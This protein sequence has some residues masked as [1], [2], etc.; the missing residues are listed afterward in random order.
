MKASHAPLIIVGAGIAGLCAALAA[1]PHPVRLLNRTRAL[2]GAAADAATA[3]A[4][5]GIAAALAAGDDVNAHVDDTV[6][7]GAGHNDHAAVAYLCA[8]APAAIGW[9]RG[10]GVVFDGDPGETEFAREGGHRC[11][12]ILHC[13]GDAT[14]ARILAALQERVQSARHVQWHR[15]VDVDG[16]L[17]RG[18]VVA[19]VRMRNAVGQ[20]H[21]L[22]GSAVVLATGGIGGL[23][24]AT[25]NPVSAQGRGLALA[26]AA[27]ATL[28]DLEFVQFHPTALDL[29]G[30][31][32]LPL[33]TEVLRGV[34]AVLRDRLGRPLMQGEHAMADLAPRDVVARVVWQAL[35]D[36]R[37]A[38]LHGEHLGLDWERDFPTVLGQCLAHG[39]DPRSRALP[40]QPAAHFHMGGI[41]VDLDGQSSVPGLYA[42]GE[43]ACNGVHG[44]NRLASNSLLE[45]VVYGRR[46]GAQAALA[47][48]PLTAI[49]AR[50]TLW[51]ANAGASLGDNRLNWLRRSLAD[52][53]GPARI[54]A[55]IIATRKRIA[56]DPELAHSCQGR[57]ALAMLNA[58][59]SR[60]SSL[61]AH[62]WAHLSSDDRA[63]EAASMPHVSAT[64]RNRSITGP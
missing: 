14:G 9:L 20:E 25:T 49:S 27:Q 30:R 11:A 59:A 48:P 53:L 17:M 52:V 7:A 34:G 6:C 23:F 39:L 54:H 38:F 61:G 63:D 58:A 33:L 10:Q 15:G 47:R 50:H 35:R 60:R 16:L 46:V 19:G 42:V 57:V 18:D 37:G 45:G 2:R 4:Q 13:G 62:Y 31:V 26:L 64:V 1:A 55:R 56:A 36:G 32:Q 51:T 22:T 29:P 28:R 8:Q 24:A 12:R 43:V 44:A 21:C 3:L 40:I 5:G 41:D